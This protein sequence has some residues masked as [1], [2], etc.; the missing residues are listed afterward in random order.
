MQL[1]GLHIQ[2]CPIY[3]ALFG[4]LYYDPNLEPDKE[5]VDPE[6]FYQEVTLCLIFIGI[7]ITWW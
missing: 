4:I 6:D 3:G 5:K 1:N 7:K 2:R